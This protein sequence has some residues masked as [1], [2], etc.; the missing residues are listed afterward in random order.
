VV[1]KQP[2]V[3]HKVRIQDF[4]EWLNGHARSPAD[5]SLKNRLRELLGKPDGKA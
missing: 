3:E 5:M 1:V 4:E 2:R